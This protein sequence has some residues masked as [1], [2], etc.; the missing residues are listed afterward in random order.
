MDAFFDPTESNRDN[1]WAYAIVHERYDGRI[2]IRDPSPRDWYVVAVHGDHVCDLEDAAF[3]GS[4][5]R[6]FD[7]EDTEEK[8]VLP[9][10]IAT[11]R[12]D[13]TDEGEAW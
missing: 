1:A 11:K 2:E 7:L 4:I 12:K 5:L 10:K 3:R 8:F 6:E 9:V 13:D